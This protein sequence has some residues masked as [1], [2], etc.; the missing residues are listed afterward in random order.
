ML[1][2]ASGRTILKIIFKFNFKFD[3]SALRLLAFKQ[4]RSP[5]FLAG[6]FQQATNNQHNPNNL[7][8]AAKAVKNILQTRRKQR[9]DQRY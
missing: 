5:R 3:F 7:A 4:K 8:F 9:L 2:L 1:E 6:K